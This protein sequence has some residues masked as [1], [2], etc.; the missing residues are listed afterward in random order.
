[1]PFPRTGKQQNIQVSMNIVASSK[2][3]ISSKNDM[4][5][6]ICV[7]CNS[8]TGGEIPNQELSDRLDDL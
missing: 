8:V 5:P 7:H 6:A 3:V 2:L 1:M 4:W